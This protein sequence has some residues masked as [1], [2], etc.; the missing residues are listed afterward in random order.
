MEIVSVYPGKIMD[1]GVSEGF[2]ILY[3]N[4]QPVSKPQDVMDIIK[5]SKRSVFVEGVTPY[6]KPSYFGF[7]I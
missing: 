3:V 4:D 5:K 7:G 1:A 2:V 6:G